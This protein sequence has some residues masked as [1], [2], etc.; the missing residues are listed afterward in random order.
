MKVRVHGL[1]SWSHAICVLTGFCVGFAYADKSFETTYADKARLGPHS[2]A[3]LKFSLP[4]KSFFIGEL[5]PVTF[6]LPVAQTNEVY[7]PL[8]ADLNFVVEGLIIPDFDPLLSYTVS[9]WRGVESVPLFS[10]DRRQQTFL[11]NSWITF[12][13]PGTYRFYATA[14]CREDPNEVASRKVNALSPIATIEI[15]SPTTSDL[16]RAFRTSVS[17]YESEK[18][19]HTLNEST[20]LA[21]SQIRHL[22]SDL[23]RRYLRDLLC[24]EQNYK[25]AAL[26]LLCSRDLKTA[27]TLLEEGLGDPA[28]AITPVYFEALAHMRRS[29]V[30]PKFR[31]P[32]PRWHYTAFVTRTDF[33]YSFIGQLG[34]DSDWMKLVAAFDRKTDKARA[35]CAMS[36]LRFI[37]SKSEKGPL[38]F[39]SA[40]GQTKARKT[41]QAQFWRLPENDQLAILDDYWSLVRIESW[42]PV[43]DS[44]LERTANAIEHAWHKDPKAAPPMYEYPAGS[45]GPLQADEMLTTEGRIWRRI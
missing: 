11:M 42:L 10:K 41:L 12:D 40:S 4:K 16:E 39:I 23:S 3:E 5:I 45:W 8:I 44:A 24:A 2:P 18:K 13:Q 21:L 30:T 15:L 1:S 19:G 22:D 43:V 34:D 37:K 26:G 27:L 14:V 9:Q 33:N 32:P 6:S 20:Y 7:H 25:L 29:L 35:E 28:L 17:I 36:L 31:E 38:D